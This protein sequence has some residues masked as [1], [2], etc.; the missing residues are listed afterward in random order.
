MVEALCSQGAGLGVKGTTPNSSRGSRRQAR[1][2]EGSSGSGGCE[3][4]SLASQSR[5]T[6]A[7]RQEL[8][9]HEEGPWVKAAAVLDLPAWA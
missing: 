3:V 7:K 4:Q 2:V 8:R 9:Y 6:P 5:N 1:P